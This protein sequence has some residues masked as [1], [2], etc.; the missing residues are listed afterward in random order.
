MP[1]QYLFWMIYIISILIGFW[2]NYEANQPLWYRRAGGF[3]VLWILVG[4]LGYRVFG[5]AVR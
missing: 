2:L 1:M 5:S 4:I 3:V